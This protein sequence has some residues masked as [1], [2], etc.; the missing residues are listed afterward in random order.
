MFVITIAPAD[1]PRLDNDGVKVRINGQDTVLTRDGDYLCYGAS[2]CM[3]LDESR[4]LKG[5]HFA[6]ASHGAENGPHF[7]G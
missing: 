6:A 4:S 7:I 3:I 2:R 1:M 5:V